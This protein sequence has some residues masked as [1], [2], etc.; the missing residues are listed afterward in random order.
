MLPASQTYPERYSDRRSSTESNCREP[1]KING[2]SPINDSNGSIDDRGDSSTSLPNT[3]SSPRE[4]TATASELEDYRPQSGLQQQPVVVTTARRRFF[5]KIITK[6]VLQL[7]MI[8]TVN[9]L[10][11]NDAVYA[12]ILVQSYCV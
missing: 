9:E 11:L 5:N 6:C 4:N 2:V 3:S 1:F 12:Q 10:F 8:E 7:L